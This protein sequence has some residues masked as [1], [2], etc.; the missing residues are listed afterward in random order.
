MS[1]VEALESYN[2]SPTMMRSRMSDGRAQ[3]LDQSVWLW[4]KVQLAPVTDARS[5]DDMLESFGPLMDAYEEMAGMAAIRMSRRAIARSEYRNTQ[6]FLVNLPQ[7]WKPGPEHKLSGYLRSVFPRQITQ[8]RVLFFGVQLRPKTGGKGGL[9]AAL[10][11]IAYTMVEGGTLL[12]DYDE[13]AERVSAALS[14]CGFT[15]PTA[16]EF[17]LVNSWWNGGRFP[18]SVHFACDEHL[19]VFSN[20][21]SVR[22]AKESWKE[23]Q[24]CANWD[25]LPGHLITTLASVSTLDLNYEAPTSSLS[26]WAAELI[27]KG[28]L[29]ISIRGQVEPAPVT[30]D[31]LRRQRK[32]YIDD[33]NER[34]NQGK[35]SR[36]DQE[37]TL[38]TLEQIEGVYASKQG[39]PT[40][41]NA[42]ILVGL[43]GLIH[44][45][46]SES[47]GTTAKLHPMSF[48]QELALAEM[49]ICSGVSANPN[50]HDLPSQVVAASG[51]QSLS[52]VGD[53][54]GILQGFSERDRQPAWYNTEAAYID[55]DSV[56][57]TV[58]IGQSGS[59]KTM[60][61]Q[62][63]ILQTAKQ[64][65]RQ[66]VIDPKTG[67]DLSPIVKAVGGRI[68]T[69][70]EIAKS[71]GVFDPLRFSDSAETAAELATSM[72]ATINPWGTQSEMARYEV[73]LL[74]AIKYG[75][76]QGAKVTGQALVI[77]RDAGRIDAEVVEQILRVAEASPNF[78]ALVGMDPEGEGLR[79]FEGTT[80]IMVGNSSLK[81][82][83]DGVARSLIER[84]NLALVRNMVL[85]SAMALNGK[86][87]VI[88]MDEAWVFLGSV[89]KELDELARVARSQGIAV[90]MYTQRI[91]DAE[92]AGIGGYITRS[93]ILPI[94]DLEE[95]HAACRLAGLEATTERIARIRG[96]KVKDDESRTPNWDSMRA[97]EDPETG[98]IIR[99]AIATYV[100]IGGRAIN[101]E[102]VVPPEVVKMAS[103]KLSHVQERNELARIAA[104]KAGAVVSGGIAAML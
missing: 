65:K 51:I 86:D 26:H 42:S 83:S 46:A 2:S 73:P 72:I 12:S 49:M 59:G 74:S 85:G 28:A 104:E 61:M 96:K 70:D 92:K 75:I 40:I 9:A 3:G 63:E 84:V 25:Q 62:W 48:R 52:R 54:T 34:E 89:S 7:L 4:R 94:Q 20:P 80:L 35:M 29:A 30:R 13:D 38:Q 50:L 98:D 53:K 31:E 66:I 27:E 22:R 56:P 39:S 71:D 18:D 99:G 93:F 43:D 88:R 79:S 77:A 103:T 81:L 82:P 91:S 44:D 19:H 97:L 37:E 55:D 87:G 69:L 23:D 64:L 1:K 60:K 21:A 95:A 76:S 15:I 8:E 78:S 5:K 57:F 101:I 33:I 102:I 11:S 45:F 47:Q 41:V 58:T 67:S 14:R 36:S 68:Y 24:D 90:E 6:A 17:N 10:E 100:D 16:R 32:R